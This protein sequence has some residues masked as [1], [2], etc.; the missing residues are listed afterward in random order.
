MFFKIDFVKAYDYLSW[1]FLLYMLEVLGFGNKWISW[2]KACLFSARFSV[3]VNGSPTDEFSIQ[4]GLRQSH[5]MAPFLFIIAMEGL[6]VAINNLVRNGLFCGVQI[7]QVMIS[8]LFYVDDV[9]VAGEWSQ[10]NLTN[11][12]NALRYFY[13]ISGLKINF[14]KS[15]II[16]IGVLHVEV[17]QLASKIGCKAESLPFKYLGIPIGRNSKWISFWEPVISKFKKRLLGWKANLLSIGGRLTLIKS[18]L[19]SLGNYYLSIFRMPKLLLILLNR[20]DPLSLVLA[21]RV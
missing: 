9:I 5:P 13:G 21:L 3:L 19:S 4:R 18:V 6:H 20:L 16:G 11:I 7:K 17:N 14:Q 10:S 12:S 15:S 2:F 8:H 1:D